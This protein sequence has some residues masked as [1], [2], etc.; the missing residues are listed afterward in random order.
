ML[1]AG[2]HPHKKHKR[3]RFALRAITIVCGM[4]HSIGQYFWCVLFTNVVHGAPSERER[5]V[6]VLI[7]YENDVDNGVILFRIHVT[8]ESHTC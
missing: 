1:R 3:A 7:E 6:N 5:G 4:L 8:F 2:Q